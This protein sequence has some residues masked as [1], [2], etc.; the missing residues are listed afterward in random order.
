MTT[1]KIEMGTV[2]RTTTN[3]EWDQAMKEERTV[4]RANADK[5]GIWESVC[6]NKLIGLIAMSAAFSAALDGYRQ[7]DCSNF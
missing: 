1:T 3:E 4:M 6:Q 5:L 7:F 2:E